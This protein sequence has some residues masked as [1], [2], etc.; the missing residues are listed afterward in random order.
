MPCEIRLRVLVAAMGLAIATP[1]FAEPDGPLEFELTFDKS[2]RAEA[3]TGRVLIYLSNKSPGTMR[4]M[5]GGGR[6]DEP[7]RQY[8][9]TSR[10][11]LFSVDATNWKPG[12]PLRMKD[13][14]GYPYALADLPPDEYRVQAVMHTN[15]DRPHGGNAPGNLYGKPV[16]H[17]LDPATSGVIRLT[18]DQ[19]VPARKPPK[20]SKRSK[21]IKLRSKLLSKFHGRDIFMRAVVLLP[22]EYEE[23]GDGRFPVLYII[24]GFGGDHR[25]AAGYARM[26]Q[27]DVP[28][29]KIGLDPSCALGHHV[30]ADS[31]N[32]GP[33][34]TALVEELIPHLEK[35]FRLIREPRGRLLTGHSSGGWSSL[36]LQV[37]YPDT[38]GG[39]WSTSPDSVSFRDF[40]ALDLYDSATNFYADADGGP[41]PIMRRGDRIMLKLRD[42]VRQED[43][44]GPGG[45]IH[46]FEAVFGPRGADGRPGK[47]YDRKTGKIDAA[48]VKVWRRYDI[49]EKLEREW[50]TIGPKLA[51]KLTII[52]G[53][54]DNFYLEGATKILKETLAELG[55][56]ARV[57]IVPDKDHG[58]I[59]TTKPFRRMTKEMSE[60]FESAG[61]PAE[62]RP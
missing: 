59:M 7:R 12:E 5:L 42:F 29:V 40:C 31:D 54:A 37:A 55:S 3:F 35:E 43:T 56:D 39:T 60:R 20:E 49:A 41:R 61:A 26:F 36:W 2:V 58:S 34:G 27:F 17:T 47:L 24:P 28:F 1:V 21:S 48:V 13:P 22:K 18:I 6:G 38:F 4:R 50:K 53:G 16:K 25:Q 9:W 11:P 8:G 51:G 52:M 44:L 23:E 19:R 14:R 45:Q 15:L 32:N 62:S 57:F 30:F 46:S 33:V 10:Q